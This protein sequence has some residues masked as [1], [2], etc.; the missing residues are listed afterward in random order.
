MVGSCLKCN[1]GASLNEEYV[2]CLL[3]VAAHGSA[4]PTSLT[5]E[6]IARTL[7]K[8]P[9]LAARLANSLNAA[10]MFTINDEDRARVSTVIEK[11][12]RSLWAFETSEATHTSTA[13]VRYQQIARL[14]DAQFEV[15]YKLSDHEL[16]PEVG[17][18]AMIRLLVSE[19][20]ILPNR[21]IEVQEGRFSYAVELLPGRGRVKM[22][23]GDYLA[24]E[25][26]L[27]SDW[28]TE[29]Y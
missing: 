23:L 16:I 25:V 29:P 4:D 18:R 1:K 7:T 21:W 3:E 26:D 9:P 5:R 12:A 2:A 19:H 6:N 13:E 17:S 11:M 24:A 10:G 22:I 20:G 8:R 15:F 28:D 27:I 14:N